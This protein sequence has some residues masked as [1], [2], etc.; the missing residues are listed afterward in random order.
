MGLKLGYENIEGGMKLNMTY[1][2]KNYGRKISN[3]LKIPIVKKDLGVEFYY[4]KSDL[5]N[6]IGVNF[7]NIFFF[8]ILRSIWGLDVEYASKTKNLKLVN[9][10]ISPILKLKFTNQ[11]IPLIIS[12]KYC[13]LEGS[14]SQ[15]FTQQEYSSILQSL[16]PYQRFDFSLKYSI[17]NTWYPYRNELNIIN[18]NKIS[19]SKL[20][21]FEDAI[22]LSSKVKFLHKIP[23]FDYFSFA[24]SNEIIIRKSFILNNR[25]SENPQHGLNH[26]ISLYDCHSKLLNSNIRHCEKVIENSSDLV[27]QNVFYLRFKDFFF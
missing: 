19:F 4:S 20:F 11:D 5:L 12:L 17:I 27:L 15:S 3:L 14:K 23:L 9:F 16:F 6:K 7:D 8:P 25:F 24:L 26:I 22:R 10:E 13:N 1:T 21:D 18:D 2:D